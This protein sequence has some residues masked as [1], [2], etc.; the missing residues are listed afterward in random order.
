MVWY[1]DPHEHTVSDERGGSPRSGCALSSIFI[2]SLN[3]EL[4]KISILLLRCFLILQGFRTVMIL[5][6]YI[7]I[8]DIK[9]I[10]SMILNC[11]FMIQIYV[12]QYR[13]YIIQIYIFKKYIISMEHLKGGTYTCI[14]SIC[15]LNPNCILLFNDLLHT[16]YYYKVIL[17]SKNI[18][19]Y[20]HE[21]ITLKKS[22]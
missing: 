21:K 6:I 10:I 22:K 2:P 11:I 17:K 20:L 4:F 5:I 16:F 3:Q 19:V 15:L 7:H 12:I 9:C 13:Y 8:L 1:Q 14:C 18:A